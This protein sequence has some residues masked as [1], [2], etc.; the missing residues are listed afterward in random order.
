M[1]LGDTVCQ[2]RTD[3]SHYVI[4]AF[5]QGGYCL[6]ENKEGSKVL[7]RKALKVVPLKQEKVFIFDELG[8][9]N[10]LLEVYDLP[11]QGQYRFNVK[12]GKLEFKIISNQ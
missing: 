4:K 12:N 2:K 11:P 10:A 7:H 6:V 1:K 9:V 8:I 3:N 5:L